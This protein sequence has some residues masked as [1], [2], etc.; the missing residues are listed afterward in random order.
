MAA[1]HRTLLLAVTALC[2]SSTALAK[3]SK[4]PPP[5]KE[6][7][8]QEEGWKN[9]CYYP[10]AWDKLDEISRRTAR[11]K[12]LDEMKKQWTG[13]RDDGVTFSETTVD[14]VET[15]LLGRP[16]MVEK[17]SAENLTLCEGVAKG[18]ASLSQWSAWLGGLPSKLTAGEC[19]VP[20]DYTMFDYL[21]IGSGWQRPLGVCKGDHI[22]IS[23]TVK[24]KYRVRDDG[25][26]ITVAGDETKPTVGGEWP[27]NI[28]GCYEGMLVLRYVTQDGVESVL[29]IGAALEWTAPENGEISY[30]INDTTYYDNQWFKSGTMVDHTA[31]EISPANK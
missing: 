12:V 7:W 4:A 1:A 28:E 18:Q 17:V 20:L 29:P 31:I 2:L 10:P 16:E 14:T 3:K 13:G 19:N 21:D 15:T 5:P 24:D 25:P 11:A 22:R 30:R 6:G 26:W 9:A 8:Q 23:G 27:C